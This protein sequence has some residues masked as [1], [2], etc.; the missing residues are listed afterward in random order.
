M[1]PGHRLIGRPI[2]QQPGALLKDRRAGGADQTGG[3]GLHSLRTLGGAA[4]HQHGLTQGRRFLLQPTGIA[5]Q[6]GA[7]PHRRHQAVV[8]EGFGE[9][10]PGV[11]AQQLLQRLPHGGI[12]MQGEQQGGVGEAL[13]D[14]QE[15]AA[16]V[17]QP[18]APVLAP[19]HR[20]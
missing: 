12:A 4:Q 11:G 19:V 2:L 16:D 1:G 10:S 13:Q 20:G 14:G 5:K 7:T 8:V 6:Q 9:E 3:A 18:L 15:A 17:L